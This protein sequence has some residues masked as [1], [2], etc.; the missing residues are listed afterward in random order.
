LQDEIHQD[1]ELF[2]SQCLAQE[3]IDEDT[4]R[5]LDG[6]MNDKKALEKKIQQQL[7]EGRTTPLLCSAFA[8][9]DELW[10]HLI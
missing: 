7:S 2:Y 10:S 9:A 5:Q 8:C 3:K 6:V 4:K 1:I